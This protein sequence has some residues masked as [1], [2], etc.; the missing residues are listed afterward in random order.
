MIEFLLEKDIIIIFKNI[1]WQKMADIRMENEWSRYPT[2][3]S[4]VRKG[5]YFSPG[6]FKIQSET[7]LSDLDVL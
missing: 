3:A 7:I 4:S 1:Y 5:C 6:I 2:I